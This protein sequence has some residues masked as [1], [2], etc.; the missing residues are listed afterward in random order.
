M[1]EMRNVAKL[2]MKRLCTTANFIINNSNLLPTSLQ[3]HCKSLPFSLQI[4]HTVANQ[5]TNMPVMQPNFWPHLFKKTMH[6]VFEET[7]FNLIHT[8]NFHSISSALK[9]KGTNIFYD[10]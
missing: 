1:P 4:N 9:L 7:D 3:I 8:L 2:I 6:R 10:I 5:D